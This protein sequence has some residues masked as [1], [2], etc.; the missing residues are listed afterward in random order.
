VGGLGTFTQTGGMNTAAAHFLNLGQTASGVGV[1]TLNAGALS[2]GTEYIG[3]ASTANSSFN[4][5]GGTN[6]CGTIEI[7]YF[8][9]SSGTYTLSGAG[10]LMTSGSEIVGD[11]GKGVFFQSSGTNATQTLIIANGMSANGNYTF[12]GGTL[13]AAALNFNGAPARFNWT[14]GTLNLASSVTWDSAAAGTTTSAAFG[15]SLVL[16]N[17]QA[18]T[19]AGDET[20]GGTGSFGLTING[21]STHTVTGGITISSNGTLTLNGGTLSVGRLAIAGTLVINQAGASINTPIVTGSPSTININAN[22]VSLGSAASFTGFN[23]QGVLNV[24]ANTVTLN[25]A[26][27]ARLGVLTSLAGGTINAP[28]GVAFAA[29]SNL[30][31]HGAINAQVTGDLGSV[32]EADGALALGDATSP[33]GFNFA[34][35]LRIKQFAVTFNSTTPVGLGNLTTLGSGASPGIL[36]ATNGYVVDFDEVV[37]GFGTINSTNTLAQRATINGTVQGGTLQLSLINSFTPTAGNSFDIL[38]WG[39]LSGTFSSLTLP[40]LTAGLMWNAS[41]LYTAGLL[42]VTLAGDYNGDGIVDAADYTVWRD[43]LG[44]V[45]PGLAANG[46]DTGASAGKIDQADYNIWKANF[47]NHSPGAGSGAAV[48]EP[49]TILPMAIGLLVLLLST[50]SS[51]RRAS[52]PN[53][54]PPPQ[55][56]NLR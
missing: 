48:P 29:G 43:T 27:Y 49:P 2:T 23:H 47:G 15:P 46:D 31:G 12:S 25:S 45:G 24:G 30:L 20:L 17:S 44:R 40:S 11:Q 56:A 14:G 26:G 55:T 39:S 50:R 1:Y 5:N 54:W 21:G 22:N 42:S 10:N 38:D 13:N 51:L 32:I 28:N 9:G 3:A 19:I 7:G 41:Q 37:T 53:S 16:N 35:Q 6:T 52:I 36:N 4:Q 18:L 34:G 33:A 8:A